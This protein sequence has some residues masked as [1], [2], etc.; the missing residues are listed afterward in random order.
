VT[1]A[2]LVWAALVPSTP[3]AVRAQ[4]VQPQ[5]AAGRTPAEEARAEIEHPRA[6]AVGVQFMSQM[7]SHH[8]QAIVM[9]GWCRSHGARAAVRELC[10]R[11][12][13]SQ[14]DEIKLMQDWLKERQQVVPPADPRGYAMPGMDQPM[15][16]PGMLTPDQMTALDAARGPAF[17]RLFLTDMIRHH[18]GAIA[19]VQHLTDSDQG[20]DAALVMYATNVAADQAAEIGRMQRILVTL[21]SP[22][23]K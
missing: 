3:W 2:M 5:G 1:L 20:D 11:I 9:A 13:V 18:Q 17:D 12:A 14:A 22:T 21:D 6:T 19:M 10:E 7:I 8:A 15:V 23:P 16:M 4:E